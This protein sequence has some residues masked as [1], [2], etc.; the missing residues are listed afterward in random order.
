[1][2]KAVMTKPR[3]RVPKQVSADEPFVV[4]ALIRHPMESG[5]RRDPK[6]GELVPRFIIREFNATFGDETV[7]SADFNPAI[8]ANPFI[9]FYMR[10]KSSGELH[11]A[12]TDD[13]GNTV[14]KTVMVNVTA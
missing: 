14:T 6:T 10:A 2:P 5:H 9:A 8:A 3:V 1:M 13:A 12:W 4:K 7:F 11:L